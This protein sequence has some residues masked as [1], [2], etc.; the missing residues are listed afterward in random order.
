L[1]I[2]YRQQLCIV[3]KPDQVLVYSWLGFGFSSR[4]TL[5]L[6]TITQSPLSQ[7]QPN[8]HKKF[9]ENK[10]SQSPFRSISQITQSISE[11]L[12]T[13]PC[14]TFFALSRLFVT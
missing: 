3:K 2:G 4:E 5:R 1:L 13:T 12:T 11:H 9:Y 7:Q 10:K 14:A 8:A 6:I